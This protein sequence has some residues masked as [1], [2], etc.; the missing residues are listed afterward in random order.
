MHPK[1]MRESLLKTFKVGDFS[2]LIGFLGGTVSPLNE[3]NMVQ[4]VGA[5]A[6]SHAPQ[7]LVQPKISEE[8]TRQLQEVQKALMEVGKRIGN[9]RSIPTE[10][11]AALFSN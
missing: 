7:I 10:M 5:F 6:T 1:S 11:S 4:I 9:R 8:Y 2:T 3:K